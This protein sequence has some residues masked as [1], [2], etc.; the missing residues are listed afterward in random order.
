MRTHLGIGP[1]TAGAS[2]SQRE[3]AGYLRTERS[4]SRFAGERAD[5]GGGATELDAAA[6]ATPARQRIFAAGRASSAAHV[7]GSTAPVTG[8]PP[9]CWK[10]LMAVLVRES[11]TPVGRSR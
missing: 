1:G 8:S 5:S 9:A 2:L 3:D 10:S 7:E 11:S 6:R 4:S